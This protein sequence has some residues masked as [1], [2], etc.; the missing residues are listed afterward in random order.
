MSE[1]DRHRFFVGFD[2]FT[3]KCVEH[4]QRGPN[5]LS[6]LDVY[7]SIESFVGV[8]C[9]FGTRTSSCGMRRVLSWRRWSGSFSGLRIGTVGGLKV[10]ASAKTE[11]LRKYIASQR[12]KQDTL[13]PV[14]EST[15][16]SAETR[17]DGPLS[18]SASPLVAET[19]A[20]SASATE[21]MA[22]HPSNDAGIAN[23]SPSNETVGGVI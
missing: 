21:T 6:S 18:D 15:S 22:E 4:L 9:S 20:E 19:K 7:S 3:N 5:S 17:H 8:C 14:P 12:G 23:A 11:S 1:T 2:D 10:D 13:P 16:G